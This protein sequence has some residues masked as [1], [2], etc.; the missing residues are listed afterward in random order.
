ML[1]IVQVCVWVPGREGLY[2][3]L[4]GQEEPDCLLT[5]GRTMGR[6]LCIRTG[7]LDELLDM[8]WLYILC[9]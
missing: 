9:K 3:V 5:D 4:C 1:L 7:E 6:C 2:S 8:L